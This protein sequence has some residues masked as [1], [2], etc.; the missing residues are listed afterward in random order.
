MTLIGLD[1][2]TT[3]ARAVHGPAGHIPSSLLLEGEHADL[4][5]AISLQERQPAV[6]RAGAGLRRRVPHLACLDFL[7]HLGTDRTWT[8]G[9]HRLDA[10]RALGLVFDRL[11]RTFGRTE[12]I[13]VALPPYL[14]DAQ[15]SLLHRLAGTARLNLLGSVTAPVA[16]VLAALDQLPW[17]GLA[18]ILDV[19]DYALTWSAAEVG[20]EQAHL[21]E[22]Q[23]NPVLARGAWMTRL[24]DG[25]A[26]HC[27]RHA[28]RDPRESAD[29]EQSLYDQLT[30]HLDTQ[31][32][33]A[34]V[35]LVLQM[36]QWYQRLQ[37]PVGD[38]VTFCAPLVRQVLARMDEFLAHTAAHGHVGAVLLTADAARLPGLA[39]A[40]EEGLQVPDVRP[41]EGGEDFGEDLMHDRVA[42]ARLHVLEA[43]AVAR[44]TH[45]LARRLHRG[46]LPRVH[47]DTVPLPSA[48]ALDA[49]PARLH[50]RGRDHVLSA[51]PCL[52]GRDPSCDLVF[53]TALYPT[54]SGRHCE[55][56]LEQR[57]YTVH[58]RSR[59]GTLVNDQYVSGSQPLHPGDWIRL[60]PEGPVIRFLG[61]ATDQRQLTTA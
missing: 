48:P 38:L 8:A 37:L 25:I 27:I 19:D 39:V 1:L 23:A 55:I 28:R 12:G 30:E 2:D 21:L 31:D 7:P 18:L 59:H 58:D 43:D 42:A 13:A 54:V 44:A 4:P 15:T 52:L 14:S 60:G 6:G 24:L 56:I 45:D 22:W 20:S 26:R 49:G 10:A 51:A 32:G 47:L 34:P 35:E 17:S 5:L 16:A 9:R 53:E 29:A 50:F 40:V 36:A 61:Q 3:R 11:N 57:T 41:L 46:D 33:A